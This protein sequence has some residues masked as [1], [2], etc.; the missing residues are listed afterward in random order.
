MQTSAQGGYSLWIRSLDGDPSPRRLGQQHASEWASDLSPDGRFVAYTSDASRRREVYVRALDAASGEI[1][2]SNE[3]G[4]APRWRRDAR[5]LYVDDNGRL[6]AVPVRSLDPPSFGTPE[7]LFATRLEE[8][9][10][11]QYDVLPDGRRFIL[12]RSRAEER[13]P[14]SVVLGWTAKLQK[15]PRP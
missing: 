4:L 8:T 15:E 1:R 10:D 14:I 13:E 5:E 6:M 3:G 9:S 2:V 11:R 12:N 7:A